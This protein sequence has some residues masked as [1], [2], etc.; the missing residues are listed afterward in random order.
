MDRAESLNQIITFGELREEAFTELVKFG[1]DNDK[2]KL[3]ELSDEI[4]GD[5]L[6][7]YISGSISEDD[8]EEWANFIECRDDINFS[9]LEGYIYALANPEIMGDIS[10]NKIAQM[11]QVLTAS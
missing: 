6:A 5:V 10:K 7:K 2:T 3:F 1:Y 4:L 8:L 11:L 9:K